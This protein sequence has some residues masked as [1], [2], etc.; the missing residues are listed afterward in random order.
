MAIIW[1][2]TMSVILP[3]VI[4]SASRGKAVQNVIQPNTNET[5]PVLQDQAVMQISVLST[6]GTIEGIDL[7]QYLVCVLL[8]EMPASFE[9]EALK[10]QAVVARTYTLR[11]IENDGKHNGAIVCM[12]SS[13]CQGYCSIENYLK[14]GGAM[15]AVNKVR[16]AVESTRGLVVTYNGDLIDATYFSC[17]GGRTEDAFAVWGADIP[18]L[19]TTQSP[20][21]EK[22]LHYVDTVTFKAEE[23]LER[24]GLEAP[25]NVEQWFTDV[26]Y[27]AG[28]G[29]A[30]I[31]ILGSVFSGTEV[32]RLLSL[33]STAFRIAI[34]GDS[35]A[36]TTK[37]YGHRVGMS[38]YGAD[39]M[40]IS[41]AT[42][43]QILTHYYADTQVTQY[44][45][46]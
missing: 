14:K 37:G 32:R 22:A 33:K 29:V 46:N 3:L 16:N 30:N 4:V 43:E 8:E 36:V 23:F 39:A 28:G 27:T 21:E 2:L 24:L 6:E 34:I 18:Y 12:D 5:L 10:A 38:Q 17:S 7:D 31:Q 26:T 45:S 25:E 44:N 41:G 42:F 13:C 35:V 1:V 9:L 11:R 20:G 15:D 19:K 40:A